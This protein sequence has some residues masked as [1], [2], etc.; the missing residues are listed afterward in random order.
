MATLD[1]T[2]GN[3]ILTGS[4][5]DDQ[6]TG[7][8]GNDTIDGGEG[9]DQIILGG[10]STDYRISNNNNTWTVV[11]LVTTNGNDG[12]DT[13]Q[14]VES[15]HFNGTSTDLILN[16]TGRGEFRVNTFTSGEQAFSSSTALA[17]G[18]YVV[19]WHSVQDGTGYGIYAQRYNADGS[20]A[21]EEF[22]VNT[23]IANDQL[24][25]SV[26]ALGDGFVVAWQSYVQDGSSYGIYGQR[27]NADGSRMGGEFRIN[28]T[29]ANQQQGV[30][31]TALKG[32]NTGGFLV[33]WQSHSQDGSSFGV[34]GQRYAANGTPVGTEFLINSTT[35]QDQTTPNV[36]A[37]NNGG[38]VVT[39]QSQLQD[40]SGS[41]VYGQRFNADGTKAGTEF[42]INSYTGG[43]QQ[44]ADV[45][46]LADGTL[47]VV[48]QSD[49]QDSS[50]NGIFAQR[51]DVN[52]AAVGTEFLVN[53]T[54]AGDQINP[55]ATSLVGGGFVVTWQSYSQD[56]ASTYGIYGQIYDVS[57]N[58]TGNEFLVNTFVTGDQAKPAITAL[59]DGGFLVSW[60]SNGQDGSVNGI[61]AQR[62]S[63]DATPWL[64]QVT[65]GVGNDIFNFNAGSTPIE[66]IGLGGNDTYVLSTAQ[67]R[68][69][70]TVDGGMDSV[71]SSFSV[72]LSANV[73]NLTLTGTGAI[74]AMG[75]ALD[76]VL[77]GN[78]GINTLSY[79]NTTTAVTVDLSI[80]SAQ[81]TGSAGMDTISGF[82]NLTG[83]SFDDLLIGSVGNNVIIGGAGADRIKGGDGND[84]IDGGTGTDQVILNGSSTAY[85]IGYANNVWS[86]VDLVTTDGNEGTDTLQNVESIHF[87]G[88]NTDLALS[89]EGYG[90]FRVNTFTTGEQINGS[91]A[92][93]STG[94][95]V[96]VWQSASQDKSSIG[97]YGQR[98]HANGSKAGDEFQINSWFASEQSMP[99]VVPLN[100]A[101]A[102]GFLVTWR[103][104]AQDSTGG[105]GVY[106]Q[107]YN[108]D[109]SRA[110]EEFRVNTYISSDQYGARATALLGDQIGGF[111]MTWQSY[112][113]D[114]S[115]FGVYGQRYNANGIPV[116][117]EFLINSTTLNEQSN[118]SIAA[119]GDGGFLVTWHSSLQDGSGFA[120]QGQRFG[121]DGG[122][123][124]G[125]LRLNTYTQ[126][127]QSSPVVTLLGTGDW[128]VIWHS[129][130]EDGSSKGV[131]GQRFHADGSTVGGEFQVNTTVSY[132]QNNPQVAA[133][134]NGGFVVVWNS[135]NQD[136]SGNSIQGQRFDSS[137][138]RLGTEFQIN[139][140]VTDDQTLPTIAVLSDGGFLV[141]WQ[142]KVQDGSGSGIFA[143]RYHADGRP[144]M[145]TVTGSAG[146]DLFQ[147]NASSTSFEYIG[148]DGNDTYV[149]STTKD[150]IT[151]AVN[152]GIDTIQ[153]AFTFSLPDNVENLTLTG[154][155][156]LDAVGNELDNILVG[157]TG[158]NTVSYATATAGVTVNIALTTAQNTIGAGNDTLRGFENLTGSAF[159]DVLTGSVGNNVIQAG[160]GADRIN[161]LAGSDTIDGGAGVDQVILNGKSTDYRIRFV[162]GTWTLVDLV[163]NDGTDTLQNVESL[164]FNGDNTN[165]P[166]NTK[167]YGEFRVNT[168][169]P[170]D[171]GWSNSAALSTG[172][173]VVVWHSD[174]Q[175]GSGNGIYA[176]RFNA[177]GTKAGG[178]FLVNTFVAGE[179]TYPCVA[180]LNGSAGGFVV[181]W[182]SV[183][184]GS[185]SGNSNYNGIFGQRFNADGS[186]AGSEF[187]VNTYITHDQYNVS[188]T[189]LRGANAGG[190]VVTW[191]SQSQ[192]GSS[193]GVYG[194]R[195]DANGV[196]VGTEFRINT[197][198][199]NE[200]STPNVVA[201]NDGGFVVSWDSYGQDATSSYGIYAQRFNATGSKSGSEFRVNSTTAGHQR[202]SA[203]A[204][205]A[206]GS[207]VVVWHSAAQDGSGN[208]VYAQRFDVNGAVAGTEFLVNSTLYSDQ[209][210][211][212][213]TGL[214]GGGFVVTWQSYSQD[215]TSTYG[216][217][218]QIYD[219]SG[220]RVGG[221]YRIN[222]WI[223]NAQVEPRIVALNDGGFLVS[224]QSNLQDQSGYGVFAQRFNA[225]GTLWVPA[226][227]DDLFAFN[228]GGIDIGLN[229]EGRGE[230][231]V[232]TFTT[233]EQIN[234]NVAGLQNGG[235]VVVWQ[236][237][238]D[239]SSYGIF[240]QRYNADGS[241]A[242]GEFQINTW[243]ANEQSMPEVVALTGVNA[244]FLVTWHSSGQDGSHFGVYAQRFDL[245]GNQVGHEFRVNSTTTLDQINPTV[246]ALIGPNAGQSVIT[247]QS[248]SQDATGNW[249]V[250]GQRF[251]ATMTPVGTEF[252][253]NTYT[254][255]AQSNASVA[256]LGDGGFV[257]TWNS[258]GQD[259]SQYGI[260]GQRYGADGNKAGGE[261]RIHTFTANTQTNPSVALLTDG[262]FIVAWQSYGQDGSAEAIQAQR[263]NANGDKVGVEFPVN[264]Y[265]YSEQY[266]P[267]VTALMG[268]GFVV[269]WQ[270]LYQ[271]EAAN[272]YG[273]YGQVFD[274]TGNRVGNEFHVNTYISDNQAEPGLAALNDGGFIVTW[275]SAGQD[276][277]GNGIFAQRFHADGT[278][279]LAQAIGG[280]G[281][282]LFDFNLGGSP[283]ELIGQ[284][285]DDLYV[286]SSATDR[287][288]EATDHG[289]D[290]V[291]SSFTFALPENVE[292]LTLTGTAAI[293]AT[294]N[295]LNNLLIGNTGIN[296]LSYLNATSAVTVDLSVTTAQN[297]VG[298]GIDTVIG[299]ENLTGSGFDDV[300]LGNSGNNLL[301]GGTGADQIQGQEGNDTIDGGLG[302]DTVLFSGS[303]NDYRISY[304]N[305]TW[306][307]LDQ[308]PSDG[309]D[310]TDTLKNIEKLHFNS[311]NSDLLLNTSGHGE[312][313]VN[314]FTSGEQSNASVAALPGGGYLVVWNSQQDNGYNGIYGQRYNV[315][316]SKAGDEFQINHWFANEQIRP[317]VVA[318]GAATGEFVVIW[319]SKGQDSSVE[320]IFGQRFNLDGSRVG[321]E[322][323]VNTY[324]SSEQSNPAVTAL[325]GSNLGG[326]V[327]T[328]HSLNQDSSSYGVYG[329]RYAA[330]GVPVGAEFLINSYLAGEQSNPDIVALEDGG[331]VVTWNSMGQDVAATDG[332]YG[333]RYAADG[334]KA[335]SEF[336]INTYITDHQA[337]PTVALL[338][339]GG[340]VVAWNSNGEDLSLNGIYAQRFHA[341]GTRNGIEFQV[342]HS[343]NNE[344][345][346]PSITGLAGAGFVVTWQ[347][348]DDTSSF[349]YSIYGQ[350]FDASGKRVGGEFRVNTYLTNDQINPSVA[351][352]N[353]GGFMVSWQSNGQDGSGNGIFAQR[354]NAD[355]TP[356]LPQVTGGAG[357][358]LFHF[359]LGGSDVEYLG[360]GGDD[361]YI[362]SSARDRVTESLHG[363]NDTIQSSFTYTL[364]E[365]VENLTL[366]GTGHIDAMGNGLNNVLVGN[367]GVNTL[368]Y[369]NATSGVTVNLSVTTAQNTLGAGIDI[370]SGF[371]NL[372]GSAFNDILIGDSGNNTLDGGAG[373]DQI[374]LAG[375]SSGYRIGFLN[376]AWTVQDVDPT[377]GTDGTDTL[378][379][380]EKIHFNGDHRDLS[381]DITRQGESPVTVNTFTSD[382]QTLSSLAV[383]SEGGGSVVVWESRQQDN[384][385]VDVYG[386][387]YNVDGSKAGAAFLVNSWDAGY[388]GLPHSVA[389][390][391]ANA[392]GFLVTWSS[393]GQDGSSYGVYG[394]RYN[395]DGSKAGAEFR[396]NTSTT[397]VQNDP[398]ATA[399]LGVN[400]G[401]FVVTWHSNHASNSYDVYGQRYDVDG[402]PVGAEFL[403]NT[404]YGSTQTSPSV[405]AQND[406]G[407]VVTWISSGSQDGYGSG[408]YGQR[409]AGDGTK[410][411][412]E[413]RVNSY[414]TF[415]QTNQSVTLLGD[416]GFVVVWES[417]NKDGS[418]YG[419][420]GQRFKAD[421]SMVGVEF[422]VHY[423]STNDQLGPKV[424]GLTGGGF[425][426]TW[427]SYGQD[428]TGTNGV[429]GQIY[430]VS[431]NRVGSE[432][433]VNAYTAGDQQTPSIAA[434]NDGGFIV[435]WQSDGQNSSSWGIFTQRFNADGTPWLSAMP[436]I[437][438]GTGDDVFNFNHGGTPIEYIGLGGN[439]LYVVSSS[440]DR[441]TEAPDAGIDTIQSAITFT[442][443]DHV[444]NLTLIGSDNVDALG[445]GADNWLVGNTG[446]NTLSYANAT[447]AVTVDLSI[448]TAQNTLGAGSDTIS[449]FE[450]LTGSPFNDQLSGNS[451]N[452]I[453]DGGAGL[454]R[455][456]LS[457]LSTGY[458]IGYSNNSWNVVDLVPDDGNDGADTLQ[459]V[460]TLH[461]NG[462]SVDLSVNHYGRG[463]YRLNTYISGNQ[464]RSSVAVLADGGSLVVWHSAQ[465]DGSGY[466]IYGQRYNANG[467]PAGSEFLI[468]NRQMDEQTEPNVTALAG[469]GGGF[470]VTWHSEGQD[471]SGLGIYGQ[472]FNAN[473]IKAGGEFQINTTT[474]SD[475]SNPQ[476]VALLG[477]NEGAFVVTWQSSDGNGLGIYGQRY[478]AN[479]VAAGT[480]FRINTYTTSNQNNPRIAAL[481]D[482]GFVVSWDSASSDQDDGVR[483]QRFGAD[484]TKAGSE[485]HIN[486]SVAGTEKDTA[487]ALLASGGLVVVWQTDAHDGESGTGV[488]G[489]CYRADGTLI[490]N[491][492][493]INSYTTD[494]QSNPSVTGLTGGGFVVTWQSLDQ[495]TS[496]SWGIYGQIFDA[497]GNRVGREFRVNTYVTGNQ[498]D[499]AIS[500]TNDGGFL[501]TWTSDG[502][503]GSS[504]GIYAQRFSAN[505][506]PWLPQVTGGSGDDVFNFNSSGTAMEFIGAAG[507][508][509]YVINTA[510]DQVIESANGGID[511]I[512]SAFSYILP[513]NVENLTLTGTNAIDA[514]ANGLD[515]R[516]T[517][518]AA[519]NT[520]SYANATAAVTIDLAL[521]TAQNTGGSGI[522]TIMGFENLI[523]TPFDDRLTGSSDNNVIHG[524]TGLDQFILSG[525][526][527]GYRI[528]QLNDVWTVTDVFITD[529]ND[530][531]DTLTNIESLHFNGDNADIQ[532]N[533]A[534][535]HGEFR[536]NSITSGDQLSSSVTSLAD[537]GYVVL[538]QSQHESNAYGIYGQRYLANGAQVGEEFHVNSWAVGDQTSVSATGLTGSEGGF[539]VFWQSP[540]QTGLDNGTSVYSQVLHADLSEMGIY[541][542]RYNA[543][544]SRAG[545]EFRVNT[546]TD[547][548]QAGP[549]ATALKGVNAASFVVT[550]HSYAQ[551]GSSWGVYGQRY[552]ANGSPVG[553]EFL[554]NTYTTGQQSGPSV[555]PLDDGGFVVTWHSTQDVNG[556]GVY[557]QRFDANGLKAGTEFK[558]NT[559]TYRD[560]Y[561]PDVALFGNGS[562]V[563]TW[564]S[565]YQDNGSN[566]A[567]CGVYAQRYNADG[568]TASGEFLVN[569]TIV[570]DQSAPG[571]TGLANGGFV[572]T[573]HSDNQD[574]V[575]TSGIY[576]QIYD[577][578][579][580]RVG[581]EFRVNTNIIGNQSEPD[582]TALNDGGFLVTWHSEAQDGSG[583]GIYAQRFRAD[584]TPWQPQIIGGSGSDTLSFNGTTTAFD[585]LGG[586]GNDL[587]AGGSGDDRLTGGAG[588]DVFVF[589]ASGNGVDVI[590]DLAMGD[591]ILITGAN[592][593]TPI[594][595]GN[596]STL[597]LNQIQS[598]TLNG[599]TYLYIG[600]NSTTGADVQ[601]R[602]S[603]TVDTANL[604]LSGPRIWFGPP[605]GNT[606]PTGEVL[607][608]GSGAQGAT[609]TASNT[610]ADIDGLTVVNYRWQI[611]NDGVTNWTNIAG[612]TTATFVPTQ[613]HVGQQVKAV[614]YYT[615]V[616]GTTETVDS[617]VRAI[618]NV[619]D[620]P[621]LAPVVKNG[622]I[623]APITFTSQ[624]F[625]S[626][627]IDL[628]GDLPNRIQITSLPANGVLTLSGA[629]VTLNQ[630]ILSADLAN[631]TFTPSP[632]WNGGTT[633]FGW[634]G[635]DGT[636]WSNAASTVTLTVNP[637][638]LVANY[639]F[640]SNLLDWSGQG[641]NGTAY[642]DPTFDTGIQGSSLK[643]D[644]VNDYVRL[645]NWFTYQNFT[646]AFW[647]K[648]GDTQTAN[649]QIL[650]NGRSGSANWDFV[651]N[652]GAAALTY[653]TGTSNSVTA[654]AT[655]DTSWHH[656]AITR[657]AGGDFVVYQDGIRVSSR[658]EPLNITYSNTTRQLT[659]GAWYD[660]TRNW[661]G[662]IDELR[663]YDAPLNAAQVTT[664]YTTP[665]A[666][667]APAGTVTVTGNPIQGSVLTA[668]NNLFDANGLGAIGYRWQSSPDGLTW[669][670]I[671]G[672]EASTFTLT[673]A[674]VGH[675]VRAMASYIDQMQTQE[676]VAS[677][678]TT[679]VA[680]VNDA[681]TVANLTKSVQEDQAIAFTA[682]DFINKF[683]DPDG[684]AL[685]KIQIT[686][687]P[688]NGIL[689]LSGVNVTLNQEI[690]AAN[691]AHLLFTPNAEWNGLT[692]FNWK[693]SDG[694]VYST[695]PAAATL[696]VTQVNDAPVG[697]VTI[698]GTPTQG[699]LLTA[700][701]AL[702]DVDGLGAMNYQWQT[703]SNGTSGWTTLANGTS[704]TLTLSQTAVNQYVRVVA[705]YRDGQGTQESVASDITTLV[706]NVNDLPT[707][708]NVTKTA[709]ENTVI[710]WTTADFANR[711]SDPDGDV[712][713]KIQI[714]S[715]PANGTLA[716]SG[717]AVTVNQEIHSGDLGLLTF[718]PNTNWSG[719][720]SFAWKGSDGLAYAEAPATFSL[721]LN[722][723]NHLPTGTVTLTGAAIQGSQLVA[724][725]TTPLED[726]DGV[727]DVTFQW[728]ASTNGSS[729][730]DIP[731]ATGATLTL[732][733]AQVGSHVQVAARYRDG[734]GYNESLPSDATTKVA[735]LNDAPVITALG[736]VTVEIGH[737]IPLSATHLNSQ[738]PDG[739]AVW[740]KVVTEPA[741]G[742]L[743]RDNLIPIGVGQSFSLGDLTTGHIVYAANNLTNATS[744]AVTLV[745]LD[746][747][748]GISQPVT[749]PVT[750]QVSNQIP[751]ATSGL[752]FTGLEDKS[753]SHFLT[754]TDPE[755]SPLTYQVLST[756]GKGTIRLDSA[757]TGAFTYTP[758]AN[759]S[760][761]DSFDFRV[762]DG[763]KWSPLASV[764]VNITPVNDAPTATPRSLET[765]RDTPVTGLLVGSDLENNPLSFSLVRPAAHGSVSLQ[766]SSTGQFIYVPDAGFSGSDSFSYLVSDG[767]LDSAAQTVSITVLAALNSAPVGVAGIT[768]AVVEEGVASGQ[769]RAM[770]QDD[771]L[772][773]YRISTKPA[774]G[775]VTIL[776]A[777]LG[778]FEYRPYLNATGNDSFYFVANDGR[779][780]SNSTR[781]DVSITPV[782]DAPV[783]SG[784]ATATVT[785]GSL[786][787]FTPTA[788]DP[789][790]DRLSYTVDHLPNWATFDPTTGRLSGTPTNAD[791]GSHEGI[792]ITVHDGKESAALAPFAISVL[793]SAPVTTASVVGGWYNHPFGVTLA[794]RDALPGGDE[795]RYSLNPAAS[796]D[797][798]LVYSGPI[799]VLSET[800]L[801]FFSRNL[802]SGGLTEGVKSVSY[803]TDLVAPVVT[804][805]SPAND[806]SLTT[807]ASVTGTASDSGGSGLAKV[808]LQISNG[809]LFVS[810][811]Q[812]NGITRTVLSPTPT[813]V[814]ATRS[815]TGWSYDL[816]G[817]ALTSE[818]WTITARANDTAGNQTLTSNLISYTDQ[819]SQAFTRLVLNLS[820]PT[821]LVGTPISL[822]GQL[823]RLPDV[824]LG[825]AGR[826]IQ[827]QITAPN[828]T[829]TTLTTET[830]DAEG[831]FRLD[832]PAGLN[833]QGSHTI[834]AS[835]AGT[836]LLAPSA[837]NRSV[838]VGASAG[839]AIIVEGRNSA[840]EGL[841][842]HNLTANRIYDQLKARGLIDENIKYFNYDASQAGV[843]AL[844]T[845]SAVSEAISVW[846][847]EKLNAAPAPLYIIMVD[848]GNVD[849]FL[850]DGDNSVIT[851]GDLASWMNGLEGYLNA[852]AL[853]QERV[854][855]IGACYSGSFIPELSKDGRTIITSAAANEQSYKGPQEI[856][857]A[858]SGQL[859]RSG[860]FFL[861]TLF[862][863]LGANQSLNAA[864]VEATAQTELFT[865]RGSETQNL[866]FDGAM[867]HPQL[868]DNGDGLGSN[869]LTVGSADGQ[870]VKE[871]YLGVAGTNPI[872]STTR[873]NGL[874]TLSSLS[875]PAGTNTVDLTW[876]RGDGGANGDL[877]SVWVEVRTPL[878][879]LASTGG[880]GQLEVPLTRIL[881]NYDAQQ[882]V[883][884][885]TFE[886]FNASGMYE[887]FYFASD[888]HGAML[889]MERSLFYLNRAGNRV[890]DGFQLLSPVASGSRASMLTFD[891]S[892]ATDP[893]GDPVS[894]TLTVAKDGNF[895]QVVARLTNLQASSAYLDGSAGLE[896]GRDYYWKVEARDA[897]GATRVSDNRLF[898]VNSGALP[899][900]VQ[901]LLYDKATLAP[902]VHARID[903]GNGSFAISEANGTFLL[904]M[905]AGSATSL[906][907]TLDGYHAGTIQNLVTTSGG[908]T[909]VSLGLEHGL[910]FAS[911]TQVA[912]DEDASPLTTALTYAAPQGSQVTLETLPG[913]GPT[914]GSVTFDATAGTFTYTPHSNLVGEDHFFFHIRD[915]QNNISNAAAVGITIQPVNDA[916]QLNAPQGF[917]LPM[918]NAEET[919]PAGFK[920]ADLLGATV[921][922]VDA[923]SAR[924]MAI[925]GTNGAGNWQY[926][927]SAG[928]WTNLPVIPEGNAFLVAS[929]SRVRFLPTADGVAG[930]TLRAWD[931]SQGAMGAVPV[932]L[933]TLGTSLSERSAPVSLTVTPINHAPTVQNALFTLDEDRQI[934]GSMTAQDV[935]NQGVTFATVSQPTRGTLRWIDPSTGS[936]V[937]TPRENVFGLDSFDVR[938]TDSGGKTSGVATARIDIHPVNDAPLVT[939][940][941]LNTFLGTP[942]SFHLI[943]RDVDGDA[944]QFSMI[945]PTAHGTLVGSGASWTYTPEP[946]WSGMDELLFKAHDGQVDSNTAKVH[947]AVGGS[948]NTPPTAQSRAITVLE[949]TEYQGR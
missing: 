508:D 946:G 307:V 211:P 607:I 939:G 81:N 686:A 277:S 627:F 60:H 63:A 129:N 209:L 818:D 798:F 360:L 88:D 572:I 703:S 887:A 718:T 208:G 525:A 223:S 567:Y 96:V 446:I 548:S 406:G 529:G 587:L 322:F 392:G 95:Y 552:D 935:D 560:Q 85:R 356:W 303:S 396:V 267:R 833:L 94:G 751:T 157:N 687:L 99:W 304:A 617:P 434:T 890:P 179:Q 89:T 948:S 689:T 514:T 346:N 561:Y 433:L 742:R 205:L 880:T 56:V 171:Q 480:E 188:V 420:Y 519:I 815:G 98:Y 27:Y 364:P 172:G 701:A 925:I 280:S 538:W 533:Q 651:Q 786:Y 118:P 716:L 266:A 229:A 611:S 563:V 791:Q 455:V 753:L 510:S 750:I 10:G 612:A 920:V 235:Y 469:S 743:L 61:F 15:L 904:P 376:N 684:D 101:N 425:V 730:S 400:A 756:P 353:D 74:N 54:V 236:S 106:A 897:Y 486:S 656:F 8:T 224:W 615:D 790:G 473:G 666:N 709:D 34:Y 189:A 655:L 943:G 247:W 202:K 885:A 603:G 66:Y 79:A 513:E 429:Y 848:H 270:S 523:G 152:S 461:F 302:N 537:G 575:S 910:L 797:D 580:V 485:F 260:Y 278:P 204:S 660:G 677:S 819:A 449:G 347:S 210:N 578:S 829:I 564:A 492:F 109:G 565:Q 265:T 942:V 576:G 170:G 628:D 914:K 500:A 104:L 381:I 531:T 503:D 776:D 699:A 799:Q 711:F 437:T 639:S 515:N 3:D 200:Q 602:L 30:A 647:M 252:L 761:T 379:S 614:A 863:N 488:F 828:Q 796:V 554:I 793:G 286:A 194:Q 516:L 197:T 324:T 423:V 401:G 789:D 933:N 497:S 729:W 203:M 891:W 290:T 332:I 331:F 608:A 135:D 484:G 573:W 944:L 653:G 874:H 385:T 747:L 2:T 110:G 605:I 262:G 908:V 472:R 845:R 820:S 294:G 21:G 25:P 33:T 320:G 50:S 153:S 582:I 694:T 161:G 78:T 330:N 159:N 206:D 463:E 398:E 256:P 116:G 198:T 241:K 291:Q 126:S 115:S 857:P 456:N 496:T 667:I 705:S 924:G 436:R 840:A 527:T 311:D 284:D 649:A 234:A 261:F 929:D 243:F 422:R 768:L 415:D 949:D 483:G 637:V 283:I 86:V 193:S 534:S 821:A 659:L 675:Y 13:L 795:I 502:Q 427:Y 511:S 934:F 506:A 359:N 251:D 64:P 591:H 336:R 232:N 546:T 630:E 767:S 634:K 707:V 4:A 32:D 173:Y 239:M 309:N 923:I 855:I 676:N 426:V 931:Q 383:L 40:G 859:L 75:N 846:P 120:I 220:N 31:T 142:S 459:N 447:S 43:N 442:L 468:N 542:Q 728:R 393:Y 103:S 744:D 526:S 258:D 212:S 411:G 36:T 577:A 734:A 108:A 832:L 481:N 53:N 862:Q 856:D 257:V 494:T 93:L 77:V 246:A 440:G 165:I 835:F 107:R 117:A 329:Q 839:Y 779:L 682:N 850:L 48:W 869:T 646:L 215:L 706:T 631:L 714:T 917:T 604:E 754:G 123:V 558:V 389:L 42:R 184:E 100:G 852:D 341:D 773:S 836:P 164:H 882:K 308:V 723:V 899:A 230:F 528:N 590:T 182:Q 221:E 130:G 640:E 293:D 498:I 495:D 349:P 475:Q 65:G 601:I 163:G 233:G 769:V 82:E 175:D 878:D 176:Q 113:Q 430:D 327:V 201:L 319:Q 569:T 402:S 154:T 521:T 505:G 334:S 466:G 45:E 141:S 847:R 766:S 450:N 443:P 722:S 20:K 435:T 318:L 183:Q 745:A 317:D 725:I 876:S 688:N 697:S 775:T 664:L 111:V 838:L 460:E 207:L 47:L 342:N 938:V 373:T 764:V 807:L 91:V 465:Q 250:Y 391:G 238:Q 586:N 696:T 518:N 593:T 824:G 844:P 918:Q 155:G 160:M 732:T 361:T 199:A 599:D 737:S 868:D 841:A 413:F 571:V 811:V 809:E 343:T 279:W 752:S 733:Q 922:D 300:L 314:L 403:I 297:T 545:H 794:V 778:L 765:L 566:G 11:D 92:A 299:F 366:L 44:L 813:W 288:T 192:D 919:N 932:A 16:T 915:A 884:K 298:A 448:T 673:Q 195:Y 237:S 493:Q 62:F 137:G 217:Y 504:N 131:Y 407:F 802:A 559:F 452:N 759:Q 58:R 119:L 408:I 680:N 156:N 872:H 191:T 748:G 710:S 928:T 491:E 755:N 138:N 285:G 181:T 264:S 903:A 412:S 345:I 785:A 29:T 467:T 7:G 326:F 522:D 808:D 803:H 588:N 906:S 941:S 724:T 180:A 810:E 274:G 788:R 196:M 600:T 579:G 178:E 780:D 315:D 658:S 424:T 395:A 663:I 474:S 134:A 169:T 672:A 26:A 305:G 695:L 132:D 648:A 228:A 547:Y 352:L 167:N 375:S 549:S 263:F 219:A 669:N 148:L 421:G 800:S 38:F 557:G 834:Q 616:L 927:T 240:G 363:G 269:S 568:T 620:T 662:Q 636:V 388:Q 84:T 936:F 900:V 875:L 242:G 254:T 24:Y 390:G 657:Q 700:F 312:F 457:G 888:T 490:G 896:V 168:F 369:A 783:I 721:T 162:S 881:M 871:L 741:F 325:L 139:T 661:N 822:S 893:D 281:A 909:Q 337:N 289:I 550:W 105:F 530:G 71:Q 894:Y 543:D 276:G 517:G 145:P 544:G 350:I 826:I 570:N 749:L 911:D 428:S 371:E 68:V 19:V 642:N 551:D 295:R 581:G 635:N 877:A 638:N 9:G 321:A 625:A 323:R 248:T 536:V 358:D 69:T 782:N 715:L 140:F 883:W 6:I 338:E 102:G 454:D 861:D 621:T 49:S 633:G 387:R 805:G 610:L 273:I 144:W 598:N 482:G 374:T 758:N 121:A 444:E 386:Q 59:T 380:V 97:I 595:T 867:Q 76:N 313:Q 231:K 685:N 5:Q 555:A 825:M 365:N 377:D 770:D 746:G 889:P 226:A 451:G 843:D 830:F 585:Y 255:N 691:T 916:P 738:D 556:F 244:G 539:V 641:R 405:A 362:L 186:R 719:T 652:S 912:L 417:R 149:V 726:L 727:G 37:L 67:D 478:D 382:S 335:G 717:V 51:F 940:Q 870:Q 858:N 683:N 354:F 41:G 851:P 122:K 693:A 681:P 787:S 177:D 645:G 777:G 849:R 520:L 679:L 216:I 431:G 650:D 609:L 735:N 945:T 592:F 784:S 613:S 772:L 222:T 594:S 866:F 619:N 432:F 271:D 227:T 831:H 150:R 340:F 57:G 409:Y 35:A 114:G 414:T 445:N 535:G 187:H 760:G 509:L 584:G 370:L 151:E 249:G 73:E 357:N 344:Q 930:L 46:M 394:Q 864:F 296:T 532:L 259:G 125:E 213:V 306:T 739:D 583:N 87:N 879:R 907:V 80:T 18:G 873:S 606:A 439:D 541:G 898:K 72:T 355:G 12:T 253:I 52:G 372:T 501:V 678:A 499:A 22:Q 190:F 553:S 471:T 512:H 477:V 339:T 128:V 310:G 562:F 901:G 842:S 404:Y 524:G 771:D 762:S 39:W 589:A 133:L 292:N 626:S 629:N 823:N 806:A 14:N 348:D 921:V 827:V 410:L 351:A 774:K 282:D 507:N 654:T 28:A 438:G 596:G 146:H 781:V 763:V 90:E 690:T 453:L 136:G 70:E 622:F 489:Q 886:N 740:F 17:S 225:D 757:M 817:L 458:R 397:N 668:T 905:P 83:S 416:G 698:T 937:Y 55:S 860:E 23:W 287:I 470:L 632:N 127:D 218:G 713:N 804:I 418:G 854:V 540:A 731:G 643:L 112:S 384:N 892:D 692:S 708:T 574:M 895:N 812:Q 487:L 316:G 272:H 367:P 670:D 837:A 378:R 623:N 926:K 399:F 902:L 174:N 1:G 124:G 702:S 441:I 476:S 853:N 665:N 624:D 462:D 185:S 913:H 245:D 328:W 671:T 644:G 419:I 158:I 143:Q 792:Q 333:Q 368:S 712:L 464:A 865:R 479:G 736:A 214:A 618:T 814:T 947:I 801:R 268:G 275:Q 816:K 674:Q 147:F 301:S 597:G 720:T 704:N 166:L